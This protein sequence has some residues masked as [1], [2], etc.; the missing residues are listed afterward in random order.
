MEGTFPAGTAKTFHGK[1][2]VV[3]VGNAG[4]VTIYVD[5]KDVGKLGKPGQPMLS[6]GKS[7]GGDSSVD[8][9]NAEKAISE[10]I[11]AV[12]E[13]LLGLGYPERSAAPVVAEVA[14]ELKTANR[15]E[16]LRASLSRMGSA[17]AIAGGDD[18]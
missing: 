13:A 8:V 4:G 16:L 12:V 18:R 15:N 17:K 2:A 9:L 6:G 11:S 5:G 14:H 10:A 3:R 7:S 1:A